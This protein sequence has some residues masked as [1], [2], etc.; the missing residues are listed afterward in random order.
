MICLPKEQKN[1]LDYSRVDTLPLGPDPIL[2]YSS[3]LFDMCDDKMHDDA[4][5]NCRDDFA[6]AIS[7]FDTM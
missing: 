6:D 4:D 3:L 7:L 5:G 1:D 2:V